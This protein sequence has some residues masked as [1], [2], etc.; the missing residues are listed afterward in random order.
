[1]MLWVRGWP[2]G[3]A[4]VVNAGNPLTP[5]S[6]HL[7]EIA[8]GYRV[9]R[10][11]ICRYSPRFGLFEAVVV[12]EFKSGEYLVNQLAF[13]HSTGSKSVMLCFDGLF[14]VECFDPSNADIDF[15]LEVRILAVF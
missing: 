12:G 5:Y 3:V 7:G 9:I 4:G 10:A 8:S 11:T 14:L 15:L 13:V 6:H 1:M 2:Q